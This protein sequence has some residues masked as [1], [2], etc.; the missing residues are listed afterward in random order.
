MVRVIY[1]GSIY[2]Y[3]AEYIMSII[4]PSLL[5]NN[6]WLLITNNILIL[7]KFHFK[8]CNGLQPYKQIFKT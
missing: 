4:F 6:F 5:K 3:T 7:L 1:I 8:I 2:Q